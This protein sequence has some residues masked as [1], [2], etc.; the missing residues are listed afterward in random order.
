MYT[1]KTFKKG[2]TIWMAG[3]LGFR[4]TSKTYAVV[5]KFDDVVLGTDLKGRKVFEIYAIK[6][7]AQKQADYFNGIAN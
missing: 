5:S 6:S 3:E 2:E 4:A 7:A 1:V